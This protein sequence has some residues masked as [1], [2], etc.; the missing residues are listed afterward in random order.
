MPAVGRLEAVKPA[1]GK[2]ADGKPADGKPADGKPA[3]GKPADGK[4]ADGVDGRDSMAGRP[5][6]GRPVFGGSIFCGSAMVTRS[7]GGDESC[8]CAPGFVAASRAFGATSRMADW[9]EEAGVLSVDR[10]E[11]LTPFSI[12]SCGRD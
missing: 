7:V 6:D 8:N 1:D 9:I 10:A 5:V 2:P 12:S 11:G 4:P 3:D